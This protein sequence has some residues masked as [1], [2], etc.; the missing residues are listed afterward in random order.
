[1]ANNFRISYTDVD[2]SFAVAN[3]DTAIKGYMVVRAPK[4]KAQPTYFPAGST[5]SLIAF[6]GAP[7]ATYPLIQDAI[8]FNSQFGLY[9]SAP[10]GT[11]TG[12]QFNSFYGGLYI[13][14]YGAFKFDRVSDPAAPDYIGHFPFTFSSG[15]YTGNCTALGFA[16]N[17]TVTKNTSNLTIAAIPAA[18]FAKTTGIRFKY[19]G[20]DAST[21]SASL[22]GTTIDINWT[23]PVGSTGN[24][25]VGIVGQGQQGSLFTPTSQIA[26]YTTT[27]SAVTLVILSDSTPYTF[28]AFNWG[29]ANS[30]AKKYWDANFASGGISIEWKMN[31]VN[32]TYVYFNQK[33]AQ[34]VPTTLTLNK[35]GYINTFTA[36]GSSSALTSTNHGFA[37]GDAVR[38]YTGGTLPAPLSTSTIYYVIARTDA[39]TFTV[40]VSKGGTELAT[41]TTGSGT[42]TVQ[43][44]E[45]AANLIS[46]S[47][48]EETMPGKIS[49]G[50][51]VTGSLVQTSVDGYGSD[52]YI[53]TLIPADA[54]LFIEVNQ[55]KPFTSAV[56][57]KIANGTTFS[58]VGTRAAANGTGIAT[59]A[60]VLAAGWDVAASDQ[61]DDV[62]IFM[63]PLGDS[64]LKTVLSGQRTNNHKLST[65]ITA[66]TGSSV[67]NLITART[68]SPSVRG[69]AYY[70]NQFLRKENYT[71]TKFYSNCIGAIGTKLAKIMQDKMG[72]WAPMYTD[73]GGLGGQLAIG[74]ESQY[75]K[76]SN[77][78]QQAFDAIG[79]NAIILDSFNGPMIIGQKSAQSPGDLNDWSYLGHSMAFDLFKKELRDGVLTPQIGKPNDTNFQNIRQI[80]AQ[81]ILNKRIGGANKIWTA[82]VVDA[83]SMNDDVTKAARKFKLLVQVK[84]TTFSE[85]VDLTLVN[86]GQTTQL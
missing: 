30:D 21:Q 41:T 32:D 42:H 35:I 5:S 12:G 28:P 50:G 45:F 78:D 56:A 85:Y 15:T 49:S 75:I 77:E 23:A 11:G 14:E 69:L 60:S 33:S 65:Y 29:L 4:G 27:S 68:A 76:L 67:A 48:A 31:L 10:A 18:F 70:A 86:V 44:N 9:L 80:Q 79:L 40:G 7:S 25:A 73:H 3:T 17:A 2:N 24:G 51:T 57:L 34:E 53:E 1:M 72:G 19:T 71:S 26:S 62:N 52:N 16:T 47:L 83:I 58:L 63:E 39:N 37:V 13:T 59:T 8:D 84:V 36:T 61:F 74:A 64:S 66:V 20:A 54:K 38:F 81:A 46:I 55:I 43:Y 6:T 22:Y 82:G